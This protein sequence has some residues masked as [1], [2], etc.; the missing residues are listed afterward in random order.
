MEQKLT[1]IIIAKSAEM[2]SG[3]PGLFTGEMGPCL[4]LYLLNKKYCIPRA[5]NA[6]DNMMSQIYE[7]TSKFRNINFDSS[8]AS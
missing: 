7:H 1:N 4:A 6:A 5:E 2:A 8:F 3:A